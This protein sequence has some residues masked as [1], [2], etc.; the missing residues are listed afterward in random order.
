MY[1][2]H[3]QVR[4]WSI[5]HFFNC[6]PTVTHAANRGSWDFCNKMLFHQKMPVHQNTK[7]FMEIYPFWLNFLIS[8]NVLGLGWNF[9]MKLKEESNK[10][11]YRVRAL[12]KRPRCK[13]GKSRNITPISHI[14]GERHDQKAFPCSRSSCSDVFH[15]KAGNFFIVQENHLPPCSSNYAEVYVY[16][17]WACIETCSPDLVRFPLHFFLNRLCFMLHVSL[18]YIIPIWTALLQCVWTTFLLLC[19]TPPPMYQT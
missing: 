9:W 8:K 10:Q 7:L 2:L 11:L 17:L 19:S 14:R 16:Y 12:N 3:Q 15:C 1:S 18:L 13:L 4:T 5:E 6:L